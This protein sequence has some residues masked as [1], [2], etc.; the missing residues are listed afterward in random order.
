MY[1]LPIDETHIFFYFREHGHLPAVKIVSIVKNILWIYFFIY[2]RLA[3]IS[4]LWIVD[5]Y[6]VMHFKKKKKED[7][8]R[9]GSLLSK[10][11]LL[12]SITNEIFHPDNQ[13]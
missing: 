13:I 12:N 5:I 10:P 7:C 9:N 6:D 4:F 2:S 3:P 11:K 8:I 1:I